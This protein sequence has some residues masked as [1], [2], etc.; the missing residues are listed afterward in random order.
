[1]KIYKTSSSEG[2][3]WL[4]A[5]SK[6]DQE[7]LRF[8]GTKRSDGWERIKLKRLTVD[9][10]GRKRHRTD[11]PGGTSG[12]KIFLSAKAKDALEPLLANHGELLPIEAEDGEPYWI[13]NVTNLVNA[14]DSEKS[15]VLRSKDTGRVLMINKHA[16][17]PDQVEDQVVFKLSDAPLGPLFVTETFVRGVR[18]S[19]LLGLEFTPVWELRSN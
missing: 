1:M 17:K 2:S 8:D 4:L 13:F 18:D 5:L 11:F 14:L 16:F 7:R 3:E 19:G 10:A 15:E 12:T 6:G 9:N